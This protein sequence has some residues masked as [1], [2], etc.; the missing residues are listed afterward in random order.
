M[1]Q[2]KRLS[3]EEII[4]QE[5][6][7]QARWG[8]NFNLVCLTLNSAVTVVVVILLVVGKPSGEGLTALGSGALNLITCHFC[9]F[10]KDANDRLDQI[11][12][13]LKDDDD[14]PKP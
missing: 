7:R 10:T 5:R 4:C 2:K 11:A 3:Q 8:F 14:E 1:P 9:R 13:E 6:I 12:K